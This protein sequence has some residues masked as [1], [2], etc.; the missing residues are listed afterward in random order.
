M[1]CGRC[2]TG[3]SSFWYIRYPVEG[4]GFGA[5]SAAPIARKVFDA[6]LL[7]RQ[8]LPAAATVGVAA[9]SALPDFSDV[10]GSPDAVPVAP[11][12]GGEAR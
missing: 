6:W 3:G 7:G 10:R 8:P 4:G 11:A 2:G 12:S 9:R 1:S 5:S